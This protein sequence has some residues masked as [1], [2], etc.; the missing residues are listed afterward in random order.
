MELSPGVVVREGDRLKR[1]PKQQPSK[2]DF[3]TMT[4]RKLRPVVVNGGTH[5]F[6]VQDLL[7]NQQPIIRSLD[8]PPVPPIIPH[9]PAQKAL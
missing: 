2:S 9:P 5:A 1:G 6:S 7:G 4:K 3:S 8:S